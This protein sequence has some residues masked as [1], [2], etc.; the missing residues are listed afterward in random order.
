M[1]SKTSWINKELIIQILRNVGWI[2]IVYFIGLLFSL[3]IDI[4]GKLTN[5]NVI[6]YNSLYEN[7]FKIQYP[8]QMGLLFFIPVLLAVFI[9][10]FLHVKQ[11]ADFIHSL[12]ISRGRI[13]Q[14]T[15]LTGLGIL[16]IPILLNTA[17]LF[18]LYGMTEVNLY[19]DAA[20]I[21][22]W[23]GIT[24]LMA[25]LFYLAG[26]FIAMI[27]GLSAVQGVL[28]YILLL[29]PAGLFLLIT[30]SLQQLLFGFPQDY[31]YNIQIEEYSPIVKAAMLENK[32]I[33]WSDALIYSV[34]SILFYGLALILYKKRHIEMAAQP[35]AFRFLQ[36]I[37]KYGVTF[38]FMLI[39]GMYFIEL[40]EQA[41]WIWFG[42]I[43][44]SLIGYYVAEM[45][46]QKHWRVFRNWK[47]FVGY[48]V[49][50]GAA[51]LLFHF[52][53][54]QYEKKV[55]EASAIKE[56]YVG[57]SYY[58]LFGSDLMYTSED[59]IT[60][61]RRDPM[62]KSDETI[63]AIRNLHKGIIDLGKMPIGYNYELM[64]AFFYYKLEDGTTIA[65][66]Y[67]VKQGTLD[68][69]Y[70]DLYETKEYKE[71][72]NDIFQINEDQIDKLTLHKEFAAGRT[73]SIV[74]PED[75]K[76]AIGIL[77]QEIYNETFKDQNRLN[78]YSIEVLLSNNK[79][80]SISVRNS[81]DEFEKW[82]RAKGYLEKIKTTSDDIDWIYILDK[83]DHIRELNKGKYPGDIFPEL[84]KQGTGL[85]IKDKD[86]VE[87]VIENLSYDRENIPYLVG[88]KYSGQSY[89]DVMGLT[90]ENA[91]SFVKKAF[92]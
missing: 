45:I 77:K 36:P 48:L 13:F 21:F 44:G 14:H 30:F 67:Q 55:P 63:E 84:K 32:L 73:L 90:E 25:V 43:V 2:G 78:S 69:Y 59:G 41:G 49:V 83:N 89:V 54:F 12:P 5:P 76:E 15:L 27:T 46:L 91:P 47:G 7:L 26:T 24:M 33:S 1:P 74:D 87:E 66:S 16:L 85:E 80:T 71:A 70:S 82:L 58:D 57:Y 42:Y 68:Q 79:R 62:M 50:I 3:P 51:S 60:D 11:A 92:E 29:L 39:G 35:I 4:L 28:T 9:F 17:F 8:I 37:F 88:I 72:S 23:S 40:Q 56:A 20:D 75:I 64:P 22:A 38:C 86:K 61:F 6:Y 18:I 52:D 81:Y 65:R 53:L 34:I 31:F 19:I 10:R